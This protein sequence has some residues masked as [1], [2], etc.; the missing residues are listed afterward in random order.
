MLVLDVVL[1]SRNISAKCQ[2]YASNRD[3]II[4]LVIVEA[5]KTLRCILKYTKH[6][7]A[8]S[9]VV[10][11][12]LHVFCSEFSVFLPEDMANPIMTRSRVQN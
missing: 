4:S 7:S 3:Y 11:V 8:S 5:V 12:E 10:S 6:T 1:Q 2:L 9:H